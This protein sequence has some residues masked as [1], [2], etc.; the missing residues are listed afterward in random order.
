MSSWTRSLKG[1]L[2]ALTAML[3]FPVPAQTPLYKE[4]GAPLDQRVNDLLGR[5]TLEEKVSQLTNDSPAIQR[6]DIPAYNWWNESLHGVARAGLA[7]V[8]PQAIGLAATWDTDHMFRVAT[9]ISDEARAKYNEFVRRGKR[10]IYQGLTFWT[11]NI[12][13]FRDPRWGRG[14]ETYGEDPYL[15]G[16]MAVAFIK[17]MQGGDPRYLKTIATAK[18]FAVHSGPEPSRHTFDAVV[19]DEDLRQ[20]YLPHFEAAVKEGGAYSV[21]CAYNSV[22]GKPACANPVLL[23]DVLRKEWGFTGY[24]VSDCGAIG[25][26]WLNHKYAPDANQGVAAAIKAGTDLNC[27]VEYANLLPAIRSGLIAESEIDQALRRLL[28][29]RFKLGMFDP[30]SMVKYAQIP[31]SE[32]DSPA[33]RE[34]AAET[35]RKSI[36]LLKN[37]RHT[38]PLSKTLKTIAVIGPN[39]DDAKTLLGNYNGIPAAPV[40]ALEGIRR[41]V[42]PGTRVLYARGGDIA[43][44]MPAF[45]V[46]PASS[47]FMTNGPDR[48]NGLNADYFNTANFDGKAH[49]PAELTYP[50]S[51]NLVGQIPA[52]PHPLF[53][54]VDPA[55][56]FEWWDG[57][58]RA[59]MND[60]DFGVRWTGYL[61]PPI[62]GTYHLGGIGM[63]AWELYL[64]G[65]PIA[66]VNSIHGF[67]YESAPVEL[68]AGKLYP[69]R[70]EY[71]EYVNDAAMQ[72]VWSVPSAPGAPKPIDSALELARQA[73]AIVLVLGLS[74][75]LEGEE[76]KV[77]VAGFEGGD[78]L[79]LG[80][81]RV[82]EELMQKVSALG[83]PVVLVLMN[84]SALAVN[85]DEIPAIVEAWYPGQAGGAAL[86][87]V[88]FGDYNPAGRLPV[89][90]YKSIEQL[91]PFTDY[92][93]KN[94]TYRFFT[95]EP[96]YPFG[97]GLSY[98]TFTYRKLNL[99]KQAKSGEDVKLSVE[100]ENTGKSDGEEVV[101]LYLKSMAGSPST[102]IR[103][104][105]GFRRISLHAKERKTLDFTLSSRQFS[106]PGLFEISVG[107]K[108]PGFKGP[109]DAATT[110]VVTGTVRIAR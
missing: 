79:Q 70:L 102:P 40:T 4:P 24:V 29:A 57:A 81:P 72:L 82:Q 103:S 85:R 41:K 11:P 61:A 67:N 92:S 8:F 5:M 12:N 15:T 42:S 7:T 18:H 50:S 96:L 91:P 106:G 59:G 63:N 10:N 49:R 62:T 101:E 64:D 110:G 76:M 47:L 69:I 89:T 84:G 88:L 55:V 75:R 56:D 9:A 28:T 16:R 1:A 97:Y 68:E 108:Q 65:K 32:N 3:P 20:T 104:L 39:A 77:P 6:L 31:A 54:R 43:E 94:R 99:P 86:A 36:V 53:T 30:P 44:N 22:D 21:M 33:H 105:E 25:D 46:I 51:G 73:D 90:F 87:D 98:T 13:L 52:D 66:Q 60:D 37:E 35:A 19:S 71:H 107:G 78:R 48:R 95:G 14:M 38:L 23:N 17:G 109:L 58:P 100:V 74:P 26:I 2:L 34:L 27:G 80:L 93:M 45:E 83:K